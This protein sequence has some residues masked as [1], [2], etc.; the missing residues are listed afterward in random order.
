MPE[1]PWSPGLRASL[2]AR[3]YPVDG[4]A[5]PF[6]VPRGVPR[7]WGYVH[8]GT[9][10]AV[11]FVEGGRDARIWRAERV[12]DARAR[13]V[14]PPTAAAGEQPVATAS[15]DRY[16]DLLRRERTLTAE[17]RLVK[18]EREQIE[19]ELAQAMVASG[20]HE[21]TAGPVQ[22]APRTR[23]AVRTSGDRLRVED[24]RAAGLQRWVRE[25]VDH[26]SIRRDVARVIQDSR[27]TGLTFEAARH[28][29]FEEHPALAGKLS[30]E[31]ELDLSVTG[32]RRLYERER[33]EWT[34]EE[35]A[36]LVA[37]HRGGSRLDALVTRFR[38]P[39][40]ALAAR[41]A[42]LLWGDESAETESPGGPAGS[43]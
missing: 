2:R 17:L 25:S 22:L 41:L 35:D 6:T 19:R 1:N 21:V 3:G 31:E 39:P 38:R 11:V 34:P 29:F 4:P 28:R 32:E 12:R 40:S 9:G 18:A 37:D 13:G 42:T 26:A 8:P 36:A 14:G 24:L 30:I 20:R 27:G 43:E 16:L 10:D 23:L 5:E 7:T 15:I 33:L